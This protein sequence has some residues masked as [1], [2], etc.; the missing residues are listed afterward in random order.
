MFVT[1]DVICKTEL[2]LTVVLANQKLCFYCVLQSDLGNTYFICVFLYEFV[3]KCLNLPEIIKNR[4]NFIT[5][6]ITPFNEKKKTALESNILV[7]K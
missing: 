1:T 2:R 7:T 3:D 6:S 4:K 5:S